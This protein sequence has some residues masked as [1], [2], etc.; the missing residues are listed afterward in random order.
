MTNEFVNPEGL[1]ASELPNAD[2]T[3]TSSGTS[4][5]QGVKHY[6]IIYFSESVHVT[7]ACKSTKLEYVGDWFFHYFQRNSQESN[8]TDVRI[9]DLGLVQDGREPEKLSKADLLA[10]ARE[11]KATFSAMKEARKQRQTSSAEQLLANLA[12]AGQQSSSA[13]Q[14][15]AIDNSPPPAGVPEPLRHFRIWYVI[16]DSDVLVCEAESEIKAAE[17][18]GE[19]CKEH[20]HELIAEWCREHAHELITYTLGSIEETDR[21]YFDEQKK[22][23]LVI[24]P[25]EATDP[26]A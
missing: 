19:W 22:R 21:E 1:A 17:W 20:A 15:T 3:P 25:G 13:E 24:K 14:L 26:A 9:D 2:E 11:V 18:F 23:Q 5:Q 7:D 10:I 6:K 16:E 4:G 12:Q 8:F